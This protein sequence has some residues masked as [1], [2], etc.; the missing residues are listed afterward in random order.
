MGYIINTITSSKHYALTHQKTKLIRVVIIT[1]NRE[2]SVE[3]G[4]EHN[5]THW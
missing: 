5:M 3:R 1:E 2:N 4:R